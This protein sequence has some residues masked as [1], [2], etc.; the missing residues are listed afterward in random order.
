MPSAPADAP[1]GTSAGASTNASAHASTNASVDLEALNT[2]QRAAVCCTEGPLLVLAGAGSGK[3]RVLTCRIAHLIEDKGVA[4]YQVMAITFTN[5]AAAEMRARLGA[6]LSCGMRGMW[7]ATFHA[8]C[9]RMLRADA[10]RCGYPRDFTIYDESDSRRL[11]KDILGELNID[12][13][14]LPLNVVRER[15]SN[16]KNELVGAADFEARASNGHE[17]LIAR[18]YLL[19]QERL[20]RAG[21]MDF[22]DLLMNAWLLLSRHADVLAAYQER[23][24]YLHIDEYQDTNRAQYAIARLLAAAHHNIMVVGDDDQSIYSWR[25]ADLR[26]ILE[27]ERDYPEATVVKL[28]QNYRST[29]TILEAANAV[30]ANNARRKPKRL[31]T[32]GRKG[33]K[34]ALY[35]ASDERDEGRWVASEIERLHREGRPYRDFA[36]FYRTNAQSR[37]LED[38]LLRAGVP[39]RI[40]GGTRFFD[41]AEI[42]DVMAYLKLVVNPADEVAAKRVVNVPRRG[43]GKT[44]VEQVEALARE[45]RCS[46]LDAVNLTVAEGRLRPQTCEALARFSQLTQDA[47]HYRGGLRD[48]VETVVAKSGLLDALQA[49]RTDEARG[50]IENIQEFFGVAQEFEE[51]HMDEEEGEE[52]GAGGGAAAVEAEGGGEVRPFDAPAA[53]LLVRFMEWLALRSDLDSLVAGDDYLALMTIHSAKGLEFPVVF[54]AGLE[55]SLFPH[56]ASSDGAEGLEEERRLAY[57]AITRARELLYLTHAQTRNL[58]GSMRAN[59]RSRF[60]AEIGGEHLSLSGVGSAGYQGLG[61]EKRGDRHGTFG[62]GTLRE[63]EGGRVFGSGSAGGSSAGAAGGQR[64]A[65]LKRERESVG[66]AVGDAVDHK[67]FGSGEV[68]SVDGDVLHILFSRSG[69]TKKLLK[70]YA[71]LVK[72][73]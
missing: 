17:R 37:T 42:R 11:M 59:P 7:V 3:T 25:G 71:P 72:T 69:E 65:A 12:P 32:D 27:F 61:W 26:N 34:V 41:R 35:Q 45:E 50:R 52:A 20:G 68:V 46:F 13:K 44:S 56:V 6:L 15:I 29:Q 33:E 38:M 49:E 64:D 10:E 62:S 36:L 70:G 2:E 28:E 21:A 53:P 57:V 30:I 48:I 67:T 51:A 4:P 18:V 47:Q 24:R 8:M 9:V 23:F 22:D 55:E 73:G 31:F 66:F 5:K 19:L 16:A 58:F 54:V 63:Q 1:A 43:I 14:Q 39:Y 40:V 60:V